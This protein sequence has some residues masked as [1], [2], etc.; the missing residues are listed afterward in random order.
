MQHSSTYAPFVLTAVT[1]GYPLVI[2]L[3]VGVLSLFTSGVNCSVVTG[4]DVEVIGD[5]ADDRVDDVEKEHG[6]IVEGRNNGVV[7]VGSRINILEIN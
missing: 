4:F 6:N 2:G 1:K 3:K 5:V 7:F